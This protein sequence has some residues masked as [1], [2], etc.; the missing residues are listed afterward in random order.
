MPALVLLTIVPPQ[1]PAAPVLTPAPA[2]TD[3]PITAMS[4]ERR[5]LPTR[6]VKV[7]VTIA[8]QAGSGTPMKKVVSL[9]VADG[10]SGGVRS[11]S[12]VPLTNGPN[13]DLPLNVDVTAFVTAD[14]RILLELRF[15]YSSVNTIT[16]LGAG[17]RPAP[18]TD[19]ERVRDR[20][21]KA[22][23]PAFANITENLMVLLTPGTPTVV[24][25][26]ADAAA[27]RTVTVEVKADI[28][29]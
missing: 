12:N 2:P 27:D 1:S 9:V 11:N 22:P 18:T 3:V 7:D 29:K 21:I 6:N 20:D 19:E 8:D 10:R 17:E 4:P 16:P 26:S 14:N 25:R 15:N 24:A 5:P 28:V 13:R 23:R